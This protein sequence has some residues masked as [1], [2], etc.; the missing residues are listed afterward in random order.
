MKSK[1]GPIL[2]SIIL[3]FGLA[4]IFRR[5]CH[6]DGCVVIQSPDIDD[7]KKNTYRY[8]E[9]CYKYT[10]HATPCARRESKPHT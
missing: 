10:P 9:S 6:G 1:Y 3:G 4:T 5:V 2:I 8:G 7:I